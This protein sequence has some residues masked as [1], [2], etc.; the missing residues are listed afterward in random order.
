MLKKILGLIILL[1][2]SCTLMSCKNKV[3]T[4][5]SEV[6][7]KI[8]P[9]IMN[10]INGEYYLTS[11]LTKD[12]MGNLYLS[13]VKNLK[14]CPLSISCNLNTIED[15]LLK[16]NVTTGKSS[17]V[18]TFTHRLGQHTVINLPDSNILI[19]GSY[20]DNKKYIPYQYIFNTASMKLKNL[21]VKRLPRYAN[22][23]TIGFNNNAFVSGGFDESGLIHSVEEINLTTGIV[24]RVYETLEPRVN[25]NST[26]TDGKLLLFGG[27][28]TKR[29][30][31]KN[32]FNS[33]YLESV[34]L[35]SQ[36]S[37][38]YVPAINSKPKTLFL[39]N[40]V[41]FFGNYSG[42]S[43]FPGYRRDILPVRLKIFDLDLL[44][45]EVISYYS[46]CNSQLSQLNSILEYNNQILLF[47]NQQC[48]SIK[49][50]SESDFEGKGTSSKIVLQVYELN[51]KKITSEYVVEG[52]SII[53]GESF[54]IYA[55]SDLSIVLDN[56]L[57]FIT[58]D[59][60]LAFIDLEKLQ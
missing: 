2:F 50:R 38:I 8:T 12:N 4:D 24:N 51:K 52:N 42:G 28:S 54:G 10:Q 9:V 48:G 36:N 5:D 49:N 45:E 44:R 32:I 25:H 19:L 22:S 60:K 33:H 27:S 53:E 47:G 17:I 40:K 41:F 1:V 11:K 35:R 3:N 39:N 6:L 31:W 26:F 29:F 15:A 58:Q 13:G 56:K 43:E 46:Y 34:S 59:N 30:E 23:T 14:K 57:Y 20:T 37:E 16:I 7:K 18:A 21:T 55:A